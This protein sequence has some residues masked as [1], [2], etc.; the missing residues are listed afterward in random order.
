MKMD[1]IF[2]N[3]ENTKTSEPYVLILKLTDKLDLGRGELV[4]KLLI[5]YQV[6][7]KNFLKFHSQNNKADDK[8]ETPKERY[9]SPE[10]R[11][12]IIDESRL[13]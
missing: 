1:T 9:I 5:K 12:Q 4:I 2:V 13:G 8:Q 11:Q 3:A 7:R 10:T 6:L